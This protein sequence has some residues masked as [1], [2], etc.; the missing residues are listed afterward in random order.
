MVFS[1]MTVLF[2]YEV[3]SRA[4]SE[5]RK[6]MKTVVVSLYGGLGNQLFQYAAGL[7]LAQQNHAELILDLS[8]FETVKTSAKVTHRNY[9]LFP[10]KLEHKTLPLTR[11]S[12]FYYR[13]ARRFSFAIKDS[14][15]IPIYFEKHFHFDHNLKQLQLPVHLDGYWQ[16]Y[17]YFEWIKPLLIKT[18]AQAGQLD[19]LNQAMLLSIQSCHS[20]CI[21]VRRGDYVTNQSAANHHGTCSL[22]YYRTAIKQMA[23]SSVKFFIFSDDIAWVKAHLPITQEHAYVD[24]N[25]DQ[26][27]HLDLW[28]MCACQDFIIANSS[29]SWWAAWLSQH[30]EKHVIAPASWFASDKQMTQDLIP[31]TWQRLNT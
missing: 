2:F 9:A 24:I 20:V 26:G 17:R 31:A 21:H 22:T 3:L 13:L 6:N 7:A 1:G 5:I 25:D 28:L 10:F 27:V 14:L 8:W 23:A 15:G 29:L 11:S 4:P 19:P 12:R 16:S 18:I 30:P